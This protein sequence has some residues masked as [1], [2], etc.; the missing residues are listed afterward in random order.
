[1]DSYVTYKVYCELVR[2][3][4]K[5]VEAYLQT[6]TGRN[7]GPAQSRQV[8]AGMAFTPP[9]LPMYGRRQKKQARPEKLTIGKVI[10]NILAQGGYPGEAVGVDGG[11]TNETVAEV[12]SR[13]TAINGRERRILITNQR[14]I[15]QLVSQQLDRIQMLG[16]SLGKPH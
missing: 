14:L 1:M 13:D 4:E 8:T 2:T 9:R 11:T 6:E 3:T 16:E 12:L 15:P 10:S 5:D 7:W